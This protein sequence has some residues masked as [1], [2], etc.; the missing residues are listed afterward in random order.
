MSK[1]GAVI[2]V[3]F[4]SAAGSASGQTTNYFGGDGSYQGSARQSGGTT[5]YF[6]GDGSY[7]GYRK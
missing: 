3:F 7:Q 2:A 1:Y 6:G 5:S 4:L